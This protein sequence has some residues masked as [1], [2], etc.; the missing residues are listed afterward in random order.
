MK[1]HLLRKLEI[2]VE[3]A[4]SKI[5]ATVVQQLEQLHLQANATGQAKAFNSQV[6][7]SQ[8]N[9]MVILEALITPIVVRNL[10]FSIVE[11]PEF[12]TLL[13]FAKH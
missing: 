8:L 13:L 5:Q 6:L 1:D 11:W 7:K 3:K 10:P 9:I 12:H 2:A 4:T